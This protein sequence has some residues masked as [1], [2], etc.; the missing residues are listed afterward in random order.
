MQVVGFDYLLSTPIQIDG[1]AVRREF[2]FDQAGKLSL[3]RII[4]AKTNPANCDA[5]MAATMGVLGKQDEQSRAAAIPLE[6]MDRR[7]WFRNKEDRLYNWIQFKS[8][9]GPDANT[10]CFLVVEPYKAGMARMK[11]G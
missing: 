2:Y 5:V 6:L 1:I 11:K 9:R 7:Y 8:Q 4:P 10:P 3:V